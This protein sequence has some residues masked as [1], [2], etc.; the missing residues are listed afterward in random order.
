MCIRDSPEAV[1]L[2]EPDEITRDS[3]RLTWTQNPEPDF[4]QYEVYQ[5][6]DE[7]SLGSLAA[8]IADR[9]V[10]TYYASDLAFN[11]T[12]H[13]TVRTVD[14]GLLYSDSNTVSGLIFYD[15]PPEITHEPVREALE[16]HGIDV[17]AA[18]TD[19][20]SPVQAF[21]H[22]THPGDP[23]F[24]TVEMEPH[25][26]LYTATIPGTAVSTSI[27]EY[28]IE[29]TDGANTATDPAEDP[30]T[31]PHTIAVEL[32]PT[33]VS[34]D[35]PEENVTD[36]VT[37]TWTDFEVYEIYVSEEEGSL[38]TKIHEVT[39]RSTTSFSFEG[40]E[41]DSTYFFTVIVRDSMS[42]KMPSNPV[43]VETPLVDDEPPAIFHF[44]VE[45][46]VEG[47]PI[48]VWATISDDVGVTLAFL[49]YRN[50]PG[51]E[52]EAVEMVMCEEGCVDAY[53][54]TI[55]VGA[56]VTPVIE[57]YI[58]AGDGVST[59]SYPEVR[60]EESPVSFEVNLFPSKIALGEP[61]PEDVGAESVVLTWEESPDEDFAGYAVYVSENRGL[62]G[63]LLMNETG[64]S[65]VSAEVSELSAET[66]YYFTVRVFDVDGLSSYS[67][68]V[69]VV[70]EARGNQ[71]P[72][73]GGLVLLAA[74]VGV[75]IFAWKKGL[76][77]L[78]KGT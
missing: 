38:G 35:E 60:P 77:R 58:V 14:T 70:T 27:L 15:D 76:L 24:T 30:Q 61:S 18:V 29:A 23:D 66:E 2:D 26:G 47:T 49:Y 69:A 53:K 34:L 59:V 20:L 51:A 17:H 62:W 52:F 16:G 10:T 32:Y 8:E 13:F 5:S 25:E 46:G 36:T 21:L 67:N 56:V 78:P 65:S 7:E 12:Y 11:V 31:A 72:L 1:T 19:D 74:A 55:P 44:P 63:E 68:Q 57:Y 4:L 48:Y 6:T 40:L 73:F 64:R 33:P 42:L 37:L 3:M 45:E 50:T 71:L 41:P 39:D 28:Y 54:G 43:A 75:V 22:Y 9:T